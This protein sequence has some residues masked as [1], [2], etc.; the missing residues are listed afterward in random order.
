MSFNLPH[1][2]DPSPV[3]EKDM[4]P[5]IDWSGFHVKVG[6]VLVVVPCLEFVLFLDMTDD[7][8][9]LDFYQRGRAALAS[10]I[11]HYQAE[12]MN[13]F[14]RLTARGE[15]MVP[16]WFTKPREGKPTYYIAFSDGDPDER[17]TAS[18]LEL[19]IFR[20][21]ADAITAESK[22]EWKVTYEIKKRNVP[23]PGS[24]LRITLPLDDRLAN[25]VNIVPWIL[26]F[27]LVKANAVFTG[28]CGYALNYYMQ[29]AR[30]SLYNPA[31]RWLSSLVLRYPGLGWYG[32]AVQSRILR[33]EPGLS[34]FIPLIKRANW[35]TLVGDRTLDCI[36]G[37]SAV[38]TR[39]GDDLPVKV[40]EVEGGLVIQAGLVPQ[41]GDIGHRDFLPLYRRVAKVLRPIRISELAGLGSG[42][43][44][45]ATNEWLNAL[46]KEF[47]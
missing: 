40:H 44:Q 22:A 2:R 3:S 14:T 18:T 15:A 37:R 41:I 43:M 17:A 32:A 36:G 13:G 38:R 42:F 25:P 28:H 10:R 47:E 29:A 33:Y 31:K 23:H 20:R 7:A 12:S 30:P 1:Q 21:P 35:I 39:L 4:I 8:G 24:L 26:D 9:I 16:T 19:S 45:T 11:T 27:P 6:D 46:D 34:H 5:A